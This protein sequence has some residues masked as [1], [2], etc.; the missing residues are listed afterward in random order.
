MKKRL[1]RISRGSLSAYVYIAP[2][3]FAFLALILGPLAYSVYLSFFNASFN[4]EARTFLGLGQ[5]LG[6]ADDLVFLK[7]LMNTFKYVLI[8]VPSAIV[9]SLA[10]ALI[11]EKFGPRLQGLFR[12]AFY[13]PTVAGGVILSIVWIW[14]FNPTYGLFNYFLGWFGIQPVLWLA[15]SSTSFMSVCVVMLT[16]T[17]GQPIILFLAGLAGIPQ[18]ILDAATVDGVN[19][20]QRI[21]LI[22]VPCIRPVMLFVLATLTIQIFQSWETVFMLTQGGPNNSSTSLVFLIYQT[23]FISAKVGKAAAIGVILT[24]IIMIVTLLQIRMWK[25]KI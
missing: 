13:L 16:Y 15:D 23:A 8:V 2:G 18:D 17:I 20:W 24:V 12:G 6:L 9:L 14:I 5:Y 1:N 22:K 4:L 21:F 25:E 7:A 19:G 11:I 10:I 3:Y